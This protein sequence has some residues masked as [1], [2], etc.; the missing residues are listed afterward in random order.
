MV[1][2]KWRG[3]I[4]ETVNAY[5]TKHPGEPRPRERTVCELLRANAP[6][7]GRFPSDDV[8]RKYI[9]EFY[10][11][12]D[13]SS[14][15]ANRDAI[16]KRKL[17]KPQSAD[18][19]DFQC[20][21]RPENFNLD[22]LH[23][24]DLVRSKLLRA[25]NILCSTDSYTRA[26]VL[27]GARRSGR[28]HCLRCL[29]G[30][31]PGKDAG[32]SPLRLI[33]ISGKDF[34]SAKPMAT[35]DAFFDLV[36]NSAPCLVTIDNLDL[37]FPPTASPEKKE[38]D[39][40]LH[41]CQFSERLKQLRSSQESRV[42]LVVTCEAGLDSRLYG[43]DLF[44]D[45]EICIPNQLALPQQIR[46]LEAIIEKKNLSVS[47]DIDWSSLESHLQGFNAADLAQLLQKAA[48]IEKE[49]ATSGTEIEIPGGATSPSGV[50]GDGD[51]EVVDLETGSAPELPVSIAD[52]STMCSP[53]RL[54]PSFYGVIRPPSILAAIRVLRP[55]KIK[56]GFYQTPSETFASV[57]GLDETVSFIH[58]K[59]VDR[60]ANSE[61]RRRL[62]RLAESPTAMLFWGPPGCGK[63]LL[64]KATAN[65]CSVNFMVVN[66]SSLHAKYVGES[67]ANVRR[68]FENARQN[69]PCLIF[70]DEC[71]V[72]FPKRSEEG[73]HEVTRKVVAA[74]LSEMA[75]VENR[76]DVYLIAATNFPDQIDEALLRPGRIEHRVYIAPPNQ[77]N[78][79]S[80][81]TALMGQDY[82]ADEATL[83]TIASKT[84]R[85]SGAD[86]KFLLE[87]T[88][89]SAFDCLEKVPKFKPYPLPLED[90]EKSLLSIEPSLTD[91]QMEFYESVSLSKFTL[92]LVF[93]IPCRDG[94]STTQF[95]GDSRN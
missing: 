80:I 75:G 94:L 81:L 19:Y 76:K 7:G 17:E 83:D 49:S 68:L 21:R 64:A 70:C 46:I 11:D 6:R 44:D 50:M 78:R 1:D 71:E 5:R 85:F 12:L 32:G 41:W 67:E 8:L 29:A 31:L 42:T 20:S 34:L 62:P 40:I 73:N 56:T 36:Q 61:L 22:D 77:E 79:R 72:L 45:E 4:Q 3:L 48:D 63:T 57:G 89:E 18:V 95:S 25:V 82:T 16:K 47:N 86:L 23:G 27:K 91:S 28:S 39:R 59:L 58:R 30:A 52:D 13:A 65:A 92:K 2:P 90:F 66:G 54:S 53:A 15:N 43:H 33:C 84:D 88:I 51:S 60:I 74:F 55:R 14:A 9:T 38:T 26:L 69:A 37:M 10:A 87:A 35:I 93:P 24:I